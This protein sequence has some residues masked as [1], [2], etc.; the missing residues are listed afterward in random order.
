[1]SGDTCGHPTQNGDGP[2]CQ[3]P[4]TEGNHCWIPSHGDPDADNPQG[5]P[6]TITEDDHDAI[7]AAARMGLSETGCARAAGT[8][9]PQLDRYLDEHDEFRS[10]FARAREQGEERLI[11]DGLYDPEADASMARFL[12]S[13]SFGYVKTEKR[14]VEHAG[15]GGGPM[16]LIINREVADSG[17]GD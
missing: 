10:A 7:L 17:G 13:T 11:R 1:M 12:L 16:E 14:E 15:E 3:N 4:A 9:W 8:D 6:F 2:P 5:R